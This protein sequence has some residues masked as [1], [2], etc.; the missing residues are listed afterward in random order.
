MQ[1][2]DAMAKTIVTANPSDTVTDVADMMRHQDCGF[3]PVQR[4][5]Q[6]V[7]VV[8]DRDIVI[9]FCADTDPHADMRTTPISEI[10][11]KTPIAI[12]SEASLEDAGDLMAEHQ[13]RRLAVLDGTRLVGVLSFGN[14]EQALHARGAC[15]EEVLL[16][17]TAGA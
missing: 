1:V 16:G 12:Q 17:V 13:I 2:R 10:M 15:A 11:S 8:T 5:G 4:D 14:L 6:L 3:V 9:R 7:G